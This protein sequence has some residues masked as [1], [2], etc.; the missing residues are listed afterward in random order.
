M[1]TYAYS[2]RGRT[3]VRVTQQT[4]ARRQ[5]WRRTAAETH[6]STGQSRRY[7]TNPAIQCVVDIHPICDTNSTDPIAI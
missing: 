3:R 1:L 4:T 6:P 7:I 2:F 5:R